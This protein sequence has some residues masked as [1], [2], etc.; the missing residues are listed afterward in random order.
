MTVQGLYPVYAQLQAR[1]SRQ[2]LA[3]TSGAPQCGCS[4][5]WI[6]SRQTPPRA[7]LH[8]RGRELLATCPARRPRA[9]CC[10]PASAL[11]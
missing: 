1:A 9:A 4:L 8:G 11:E 10:K 6:T 7:S 2:R 3:S 5:C